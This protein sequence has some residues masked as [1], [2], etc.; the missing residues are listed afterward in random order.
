MLT[1]TNGIITTVVTDGA[2]EAYF[3]NSGFSVVDDEV[4]AVAETDDFSTA[5]NP[6]EENVENDEVTEKPVSMWTKTE[7]KNYAKEHGISLVGTKNIEEARA[8][9]LQY[10]S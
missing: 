7:I 3:K 4:E 1:I 5:E 10:L 8:I 2:F 9:V 6:A